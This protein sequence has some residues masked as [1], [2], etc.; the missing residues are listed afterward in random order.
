MKRIATLILAA[1]ALAALAAP[2]AAGVRTPF[3]DRLE[4][5]QSARIAFGVRSGAL[6]PRE[7]ARLR[8]GQARIHRLELRARADGRVTARERSILLRAQR[9]EQRVL[10][11]LMH[12]R[13]S[14]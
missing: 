13:W 5:R 8:A 1:A 3:L 7:A 2:A 6:T 9:H 10:R 14:V 12:N 11:R 4:A